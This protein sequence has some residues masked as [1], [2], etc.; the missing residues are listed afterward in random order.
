V[1]LTLGLGLAIVIAPL[2]A[3]AAVGSKA[4]RTTENEAL[5]PTFA[6]G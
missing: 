1:V 3:E 2:T 5:Q 6:G 4:S